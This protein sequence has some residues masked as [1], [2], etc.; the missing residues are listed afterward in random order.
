MTALPQTWDDH[1]RL[2]AR[3]VDD[4]AFAQAIARVHAVTPG[5]PLL[6][7]LPDTIERGLPGDP[8]WHATGHDRTMIGRYLVAAQVAR[9]RRVLDACC[10]LGWGA[11]LLSSTAREVHAFD[12]NPAALAFAHAAWG[13]GVHWHEAD[14][15]KPYASFAGRFD[16]VAAMEILE[17]FPYQDGLRLLKNLA[18]ALRPSGTLIGTTWLSP[19]R[20]IA[21]AKD[22]DNPFH[23][24]MWTFAELHSALAE[25]FGDQIDLNEWMFTVRKRERPSE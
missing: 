20:A 13:T 5:H 12:R 7:N 21:D 14:A 17:H 24:H 2:L 23:L 9:G 15:L 11:A 8:R 6:A 10:G 22:R 4:P 1:Q 19:T 16:V 25:H 3:H 18:A